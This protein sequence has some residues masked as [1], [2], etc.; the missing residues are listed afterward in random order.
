M[1]FLLSLQSLQGLPVS[2]MR[3]SPS[4]GGGARGL[5]HILCRFPCTDCDV[6]HLAR[7]LAAKH[8]PPA[9]LEACRVEDRRAGRMERSPR[10]WGREEGDMVTRPRREPAPGVWA[11]R[12]GPALHDRRNAVGARVEH[13]LGAEADAERVRPHGAP[14][15]QVEHAQE[16]GAGEGYSGPRNLDSERGH[17]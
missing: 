16:R 11:G 7:L 8:R 17:L 3:R 13:E 5:T 15:A 6:L 4:P 12:R 1:T 14:A 2:P 9:G 10:R